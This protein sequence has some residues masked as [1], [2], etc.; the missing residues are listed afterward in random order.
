MYKLYI[1]YTHNTFS[2]ISK[3]M[4]HNMV[5]DSDIDDFIKNGDLDDYD[6]SENS[7]DEGGGASK[8]VLGK[9]VFLWIEINILNITK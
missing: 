5:S 2:F 4:F 8:T 7:G 6:N 1:L 9:R 3:F